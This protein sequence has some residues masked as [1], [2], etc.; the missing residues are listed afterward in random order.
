MI[1]GPWTQSM[2]GVHGSGPY[3]D[4]P[5]PYFDGPGP[6]FDGPGRIGESTKHGPPPWTGS[7][8]WVQQNMDRGHGPPFMDRVHGPPYHGP[9]IFTSRGCTINYNLMTLCSCV[10]TPVSVNHAQV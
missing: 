6:Y 4:G 5:G 3:F 10:T 9:P 2:K 1:G 7:M 8:D